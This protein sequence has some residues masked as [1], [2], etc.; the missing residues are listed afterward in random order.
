VREILIK[1]ERGRENIN[2]KTNDIH[3]SRK[4]GGERESEIERVSC[5]GFGMRT[6]GR[7]TNRET[8]IS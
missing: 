8:Q 5:I 7:Q 6:R 4:A 2:E 3:L 1:R